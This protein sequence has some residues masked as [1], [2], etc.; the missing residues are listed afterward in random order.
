[1]LPLSKSPS[2]VLCAVLINEDG[3]LLIK[4][5][6]A[7]KAVSVRDRS[8]TVATSVPGTRTLPPDIATDWASVSAGRA[9]LPILSSESISHVVNTY[10]VT[11][12]TALVSS[13]LPFH[14]GE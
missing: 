8:C 10:C 3:D 12:P 11:H 5:G 9:P 13:S 4:D 6:G 1:M 7:A 2:D 14:S